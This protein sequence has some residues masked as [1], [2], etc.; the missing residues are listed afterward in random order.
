MIHFG[1]SDIVEAIFIFYFFSNDGCILYAKNV[2][3][4]RNWICWMGLLMTFP[5]N[6]TLFNSSKRKSFSPLIG[7]SVV[8]N[9]PV[10]KKPPFLN[11]I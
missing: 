7:S 10:N 3:L 8:L 5:A 6:L 9:N 2:C 4:T 1:W 11:Q